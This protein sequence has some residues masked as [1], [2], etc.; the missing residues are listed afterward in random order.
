LTGA[1]A[2]LAVACLLADA[3]ASESKRARTARERKREAR[4]KLEM[5]ILRCCVK[6]GERAPN[7]ALAG[8]ELER[9]GISAD[10]FARR[11]AAEQ[12][13]AERDKLHKYHVSAAS[14][15]AAAYDLAAKRARVQN[16]ERAARELRK[17]R[18]KYLK[19]LQE[20]PW[21]VTT[22]DGRLWLGDEFLALGENR[23]ARR[24]YAGLLAEHD[25]DGDGCALPD[26]KLP[27]FK[28]LKDAL[29]RARGIGLE[30]LPRAREA[31]DEVETCLRGRPDRKRAG[32]IVARRR[33]RDYPLGVKLIGE[34]LRRHPGYGR[35][36]AGKPSEPL[37]ALLRVRDEMRLRHKLFWARSGLVT[38]CVRLARLKAAQGKSKSAAKLCE[39]GLAASRLTVEYR[40]RDADVRLHRA[41]CLLGAGHAARA[42]EEYRELRTGSTDGGEVWWQATRGLFR[43]LVACGDLKGARLV[44]VLSARGYPRA[45]ERRWPDWRKRARALASRMTVTASELMG[46]KK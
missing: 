2:L 32:V 43:A 44:L 36:P 46:Q 34:F 10:W 42:R 35:D 22:L 30:E 14:R 3:S 37:K 31:L 1:A 25:P 26:R 13:P 27:A 19:V 9:A 39:E 40:P 4:C 18:G 17:S 24:M 23:L 21:V 7:I 20:A 5:L 28:S 45:I 15:L 8:A 6:L 33:P 16:D 29:R 12:D 41:E 38:A 11:A